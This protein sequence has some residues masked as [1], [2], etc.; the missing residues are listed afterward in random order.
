NTPPSEVQ[1]IFKKAGLKNFSYADG[2]TTFL[3]KPGVFKNVTEAQDCR[4]N[5]EPPC[6]SLV[7][8]WVLNLEESMRKYLDAYI[9]GIFI[10]PPDVRKLRELVSSAPYNEVYEIARNGYN[11]FT[12]SPMP[13]YKLSIKTADVQ[14][15]GTDVKVL[16]TLT[17]ASGAKLE[18]LPYDSSLAGALERDSM[19]YVHLEGIDLGE[20]KNLSVELLTSDINSA[21]LP[22]YIDIERSGL[23]QKVRFCFNCDKK[24]K[25]WLTKKS[26]AVTKL[27]SD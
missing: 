24:P 6:F 13:R 14:M 22:E 17:G 27:P 15:A 18:S 21:W 3:S 9:D 23:H 4:D 10:D 1:E 5:N 7:Y 11:P 25:E 20:I 26:G 16:F 8:T 19:T 12:V 2:I